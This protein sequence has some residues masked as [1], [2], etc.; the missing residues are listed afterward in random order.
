MMTIA[1]IRREEKR[2]IVDLSEVPGCNVDKMGV[3]MRAWGD[4]STKKKAL[5]QIAD[6]GITDNAVVSGNAWV[7]GKA[8]V[9][10]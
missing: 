5:L 6:A 9:N 3:V 10:E 8:E 2:W 7:S 4:W 1:T